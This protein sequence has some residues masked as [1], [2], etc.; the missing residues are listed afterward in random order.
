MFKKPNELREKFVLRALEET[1]YQAR[2]NG[3]S[4]YGERIGITGNGTPWDGAFIDVVARECGLPL[5]A[6]V[7]TPTAIAEYVRNGR[8]YRKPKRG[9]IVFFNFS[10]DQ[11]AAF[12][13]PHVGI[14]VDATAWDTKRII[15]TVEA[16]VH[17][18]LP[19]GS[20]LNDGV[21]KRLRHSTDV[22]GFGRP[23]FN[24]KREAA[25]DSVPTVVPARLT[26]GKPSKDIATVQL[27][28]SRV[29]DVKDMQRGTWCP[30][31]RAAY[32][33][34]QRTVGYVGPNA[35]GEPDVASLTRLGNE[36]RLFKLNG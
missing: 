15:Q 24:G 1:G 16:Q 7:Y 3:T 20:Q 27:A 29:T 4:Y 2:A 30:K 12:N 35:N 23:A 13:G 34:F 10:P 36:T 31:T 32:A 28:L 33:Y 14:V 26:A 11:A 19:K 21:Y 6:H 22:L 25:S 9:D 18:G 5:H 17:S 8:L